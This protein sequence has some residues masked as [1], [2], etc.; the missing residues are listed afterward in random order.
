MLPVRVISRFS[1]DKHA[2]TRMSLGRYGKPESTLKYSHLMP[3]QLYK[4]SKILIACLN[5]PVLG[6]FQDDPLCVCR[7]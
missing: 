7:Y 6:K 4:H 1:K 2:G 5:G 3:I